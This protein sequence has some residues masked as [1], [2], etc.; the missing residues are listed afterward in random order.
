MIELDAPLYPVLTKTT[1]AALH[2][3]SG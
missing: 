1:A 3:P 2:G